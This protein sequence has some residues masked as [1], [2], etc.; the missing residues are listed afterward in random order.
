MTEITGDNRF[1]AQRETWKTTGRPPDTLWVETPSY[2]WALEHRLDRI[3]F[4]LGF[5]RSEIVTLQ[6]GLPRWG[7]GGG[8]Q[9][10]KESL[11]HRYVK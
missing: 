7:A 11:M 2:Q 6:R 10:H 4:A 8:S 9:A 5:T 1:P 3:F